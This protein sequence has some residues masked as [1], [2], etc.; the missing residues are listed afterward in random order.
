MFL[1]APLRRLRRQTEGTMALEVLAIVP[2]FVAAVML[3]VTAYG[4]FKAQSRDAKAAHAIADAVGRETRAITPEY[5]D[6][7][8]NLHQFIAGGASGAAIRLAV[9]EYNPWR[10]DYRI[11]WHM[12]RKTQEQELPD[13]T[14][15]NL[16]KRL[17]KLADYEAVIVLETFLNH[18]P[19]SAK[20]GL[21]PITFSHTV[22]TRPR[23]GPQVCRL[24][25]GARSC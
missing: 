4:Y 5:M 17:P 14:V 23:N 2:M 20:V 7:L 19:L 16:R 22:V 1:L 9:V 18:Q 15:E 10:Q 12:S 13:L 3:A 11:R 25:S 24:V 6:T 21:D 8:F